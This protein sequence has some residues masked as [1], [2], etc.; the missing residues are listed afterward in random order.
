MGASQALPVTSS[1]A[2]VDISP[3]PPSPRL[4]LEKHVSFQIADST[5]LNVPSDPEPLP[6]S[7]S[8]R[9]SSSL[10]KRYSPNRPSPLHRSSTSDDET[11]AP[12]VA[13]TE[14]VASTTTLRPRASSSASTES[15]E[16]SKS[17]NLA[18]ST[19]S[20]VGLTFTT[21]KPIAI[22]TTENAKF[23]KQATPTSP[24]GKKPSLLSKMIAES[25]ADKTLL[26]HAVARRRRQMMRYQSSPDMVLDGKMD[27]E[28]YENVVAPMIE[29]KAAAQ[30]P[31]RRVATY[32]NLPAV[33]DQAQDLH[34]G[35]SSEVDL[36]TLSQQ[37]PR[38]ERPPSVTPSWTSDSVLN[39][40][41]RG[42]FRPR[43]GSAS[44]RASRSSS[45]PSDDDRQPQSAAPRL[46]NLS[47]NA[48]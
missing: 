27:L 4:S 6:H 47:S 21:Q 20:E 48:W 30:L 1:P 12:V 39:P 35:H 16:S 40:E 25:D 42:M 41:I 19:I 33:M 26:H 29:A 7:G 2:P 15:N 9:R 24:S 32:S 34:R 11:R 36:R 17:S 3:S 10:S 37:D 13:A 18:S 14:S 28:T 43:A 5:M 38:T 44:S 8:S 46:E 45:Q 22:A 31:A 23:V